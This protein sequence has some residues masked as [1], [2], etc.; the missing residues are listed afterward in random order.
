MR[1]TTSAGK[2]GEEYA[3]G[4]LKK[5]GYRILAQNFY[6]RFGEIDIVA[7]DKKDLVFVEVKT[8]WSKSFGNPEEAVT[9][10]K[11][12]HLTRAAEYF[13]L[14]N[15]H[16]PDIMRFDVVATDIKDGKVIDAR[17]LKNVTGF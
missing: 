13:K 6:S 2:L 16:T 11:L 10:L 7:V 4:L 14:M 12:R 9:P 8:R 3:L 5:N 17:I 15:P 1:T